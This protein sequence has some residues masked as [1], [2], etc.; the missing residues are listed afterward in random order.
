MFHYHNIYWNGFL[1]VHLRLS[2]LCY[3][4]LL[5]VIFVPGFVFV[6]WL[7]LLPDLMLWLYTIPFRDGPFLLK[8]KQSLGLTPDED[9]GPVQ[10][11]RGESFSSARQK[12]IDELKKSLQ[13]R[14]ECVAVIQAMSICNFRSWPVQSDDNKTE[15]AG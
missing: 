10:Q 11:R 1:K 14:F 3:C 13:S 9:I 2:Q 5:C 12:L 7:I 4:L 8:G 6:R 15:I